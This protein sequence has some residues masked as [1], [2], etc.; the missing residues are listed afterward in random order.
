MD[1]GYYYL[2]SYA[3]WKLIPSQAFTF[4]VRKR[5]IIPRTCHFYEKKSEP[6]FWPNSKNGDLHTDMYVVN[7]DSY[8]QSY[9][10]H[11][12]RHYHGP[13]CDGLVRLL[14]IG[15]CQGQFDRLF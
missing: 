4:G 13:L 9:H 11:S 7:Y 15:K 2:M 3:N 8:A 5:A 6:P 14:L 10:Y 12:P 1:I